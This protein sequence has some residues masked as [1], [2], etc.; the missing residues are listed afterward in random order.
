MIWEDVTIVTIE[1]ATD[2]L[3]SDLRSAN[4]K[5]PK[6]MSPSQHSWGLRDIINLSGGLL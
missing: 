6:F 5:R 1:D 2:R 4:G 3:R